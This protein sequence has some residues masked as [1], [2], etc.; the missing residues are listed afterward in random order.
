MVPAY[1]DNRRDRRLLKG[2]TVDLRFPIALITESFVLV[3]LTGMAILVG[4]FILNMRSKANF[5]FTLMVWGASIQLAT[6]TILVGLAYMGDDAP[7]NLKITIKTLLA[8]GALVAA[9]L[10]AKRQSH[11][12]GKLQPFFHT[13]GGF[14]VINLVIAVLW[15]PELYV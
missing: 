3:H 1:Y 11:G 7:D 10:G 2:N 4:A 9:I 12:E 15:N 5:P 13:A 8:T 6:G 14:A